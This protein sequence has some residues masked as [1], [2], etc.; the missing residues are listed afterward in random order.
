M[1][2][3]DLPDE[4]VIKIASEL[5][6]GEWD[7]LARLL[8]LNPPSDRTIVLTCRWIQLMFESDET[9]PLKNPYKNSSSD[10]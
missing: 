4:A 9:S 7:E 2:S 1:I 8:D 5:T 3:P 10:C 6:K